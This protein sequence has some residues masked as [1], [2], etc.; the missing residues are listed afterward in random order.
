MDSETSYAYVCCSRSFTDLFIVDCNTGALVKRVP[1]KYQINCIKKSE[2]LI[3]FNTTND[4]VFLDKRTHNILKRIEKK[5]FNFIY[6][7][8][9]NDMYLLTVKF[10]N[11]KNSL[12]L[13]DYNG[14]LI[15]TSPLNID[16][17]VSDFYVL[18]NRIIFNTG[19]FYPSVH[20][21]DFYSK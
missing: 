12:V 14:K 19:S 9:I 18:E 15:S 11:S 20:V 13:L 21:V 17:E 3:I 8:I 1:C 6:F 10:E 7:E 5:H 4:L 16:F 2:N